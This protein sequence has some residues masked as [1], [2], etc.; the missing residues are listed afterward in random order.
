VPGFHEGL[1]LHL[2]ET[3]EQLR[4][5][6]ATRLAGRHVAWHAG[7]A[8]VPRGPMLLLA[9]EFFDAL[10]VRQLVGT[11]R[12]WFERCVALAEDRRLEFRLATAPSPLGRLLPAATPGAVAEV[13][14]A[15]RRLARAIGE[16]IARDG[17]VALLIDYG[18]WAHGPSGDTLQATR[19]HAPC[20][21]L[22]EPGSAD[23]TTHVDFRALAQAAQE[24]GAA[25]YGPVPQG[26]FLAALGI[27]LRTAK[28][29]QRA[30]PA[31]R[32]ELRAALFRL[33]DPSAMGELFKVLALAG[34]RAPPPPGFAA[35]TLRPC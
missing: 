9:N 4:R 16:R 23:L 15:R 11:A 18:A 29:L 8:E 12:G 27:H 13:S 17:G 19:G 14:P 30:T 32:R 22:A 25:I 33:I 2:V 6:Q 24:G 34:P 28:L 10:P 35:P 26:T 31:Q 21:P 7:L 1:R 5:V 20:D 3:G